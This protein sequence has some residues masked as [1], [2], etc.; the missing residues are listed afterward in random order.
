MLSQFKE[1]VNPESPPNDLEI[2]NLEFIPTLGS[3]VQSGEDTY[4]SPDSQ[5]NIPPNDNGSWAKQELQSLWEMFTSWL[6]PEKQSKKQMISQLV[7][8]QFLITGLYKDKVALKEKWESSGRNMGRFMEGLTDECLKAPV[9]VHVSMQG[10]EALCSENMPLKEVIMLLKQQQ[11]AI[12]PTQENAR[13]SLQLLQHMSLA[14]G[15]EDS[16]DSCESPWDAIEGNGS[17]NSVGTAMDSLLT[18]QRAQYPEPKE[19]GLCYRVT[20]GVRKSSPGP[21]RLQEES[22]RAPASEDVPI[23]VKPVLLSRIDQSKDTGDGHHPSWN[24]ADVNSDV[25]SITNEGDSLIIQREQHSKPDEGGVP[26]G[27]P[28]DSRKAICDASRSPWASSSTGLS[29]EVSRF[30]SRPEQ[31]TFVPVPFCKNH[32]ANSTWDAHQGTLYRDSKPHK[33]EECPRTFKY[34]CN[35]SVHE[36]KHGKKRSL[37]CTEC[38]KGFNQ[39][40]E[41]QVH[42]VRH[43]PEKPFLCSTCGR[44]FNHRTNLQA[45]ERIHTGEKP[46]ICSLCSH[47]FRQ[48][49]TFHRHMRN[50]HKSE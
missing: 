22:L 15:H 37:F 4:N 16:E 43:K 18:V 44:S 23:A 7:L 17:A 29:M 45:H 28:H 20:Q 27:V 40:S 6:Q 21:F 49:S 8:E 48:S 24:T 9:M 42:E 5:L 10:Q 33:Y 19:G 32:E 3:A 35:L 36:R 47:S 11:S 25:S 30:L 1:T 2:G 46:Y 14:A 38:Q 26:Y 39:G 13:T 31:L 12:T 41:L 50:F 34:L